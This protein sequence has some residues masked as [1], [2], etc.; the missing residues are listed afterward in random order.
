MMVQKKPWTINFRGKLVS[1]LSLHALLEVVLSE[2]SVQKVLQPKLHDF[3][4][5][6]RLNFCNHTPDSTKRVLRSFPYHNEFLP[7]YADLY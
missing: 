4:N 5:H 1:H 6:L 2:I 7:V 3:T